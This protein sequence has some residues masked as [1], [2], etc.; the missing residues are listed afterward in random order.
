[1]R[2]GD[3]DDSSEFP[4]IAFEGR[5]RSEFKVRCD[6]NNSTEYRGQYYG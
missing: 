3:I 5:L 1:M 2:W 4:I 6:H